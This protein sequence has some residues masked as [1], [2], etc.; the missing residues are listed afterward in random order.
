M[1]DDSTKWDTPL[2]QERAT[3]AGDG[4][5]LSLIPLTCQ[6]LISGPIAACLAVSG[7]KQAFGWPDIVTG[8][9]YALRL[10]RDRLLVVNGGQQA[11]GWD[12][13][14]VAVSDMTGAYSVIEID[15]PQAIDL[16]NSGTE[17]S[18]DLPSGTVAR[19]F[20][21]FAT[22]IYRWQSLTCYRLHIQRCYLEAIWKHM[23]S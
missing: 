21:G 20:H 15:G 7:Q 3:I 18:I 8:Q 17:L 11:E 22:L 13:R 5:E 1:R 10:R 9:P 23:Q 14:G 12:E 6:T 2:G 16:L 4:F 19:Q